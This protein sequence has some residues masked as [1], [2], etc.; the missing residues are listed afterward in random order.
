MDHLTSPGQRLSLPRSSDDTPRSVQWGSMGPGTSPH[1]KV[2]QT[3]SEYELVR[4]QV[5]E[6]DK[7]TNQRARSTPILNTP[8]EH[9]GC[10]PVSLTQKSQSTTTPRKP[11]A[12]TDKLSPLSRHVSRAGSRPSSPVCRVPS[13]LGSLTRKNFTVTQP[14]GFT[15]PGDE[16]DNEAQPDGVGPK[17][18]STCPS[19]KVQPGGTWSCSANSSTLEAGVVLFDPSSHLKSEGT[20]EVKSRLH[21]HPHT[22]SPGSAMSTLAQ[23]QESTVSSSGIML[24]VN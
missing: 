15:L 4:P 16:S 17:R 1:S 7:L 10:F 2:L 3:S 9:K 20:V 18:S 12:P 24:N 21:S 6:R 14:S 19:P 23:P 22:S 13:P 8:K 11:S 5:R